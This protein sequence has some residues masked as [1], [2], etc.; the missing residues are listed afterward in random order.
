VAD[1]DVLVTDADP[2]LVTPMAEVAQSLL[3]M[4]R[5]AQELR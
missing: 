1:I 4:A 5:A 3:S 2:A